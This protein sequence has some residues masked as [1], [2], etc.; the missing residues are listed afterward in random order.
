[1]DVILLVI[2]VLM[3]YMAVKVAK[4]SDVLVRIAGYSNR[5]LRGKWIQIDIFIPMRSSAS[6][7]Y[8]IRKVNLSGLTETLVINSFAEFDSLASGKYLIGTEL[9]IRCCESFNDGDRENILALLINRQDFALQ[10][11]LN[12]SEKSFSFI[13]SQLS[14]GKPLLL[15]VYGKLIGSVLNGVQVGSDSFEILGDGQVSGPDYF[16]QRYE[17]YW[18]KLEEPEREKLKIFD[19]QFRHCQSLANE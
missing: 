15:R 8:I 12:C 10:G 14:Y 4:N 18:I 17:D 13:T 7:L 16:C 1:M 6:P 5:R 2:L 3:A 9:E 11:H 19:E